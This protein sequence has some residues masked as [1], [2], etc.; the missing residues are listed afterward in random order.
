[1]HFKKRKR[2]AFNTR[3]HSSSIESTRSS[4]DL[5]DEN[6]VNDDMID[7]NKFLSNDSIR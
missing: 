3:L 4:H 5:E 2:R 6:S 1:M 7:V